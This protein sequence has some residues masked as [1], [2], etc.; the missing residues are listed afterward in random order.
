MLLK[1]KPSTARC[2]ESMYINYLLSDPDNATC[3][4][5]SEILESVSHDSINLFLHRERFTPKDLF[6][7]EKEKIE[8][9]GGI[10]SIDDTV[11]DKP[12][13]DL[14]KSELIGMYWSGKHK[15]T[16][17]GINL[18]TLFYTDIQGVSVPVNFR[19]YDKRE[20]KTKNDYFL[21]ML[22]ESLAWGINPAWVTGDSW[23][24]ST[25]NLKKI[26]R[27]NLNFL[28]GIEQN[29]CVSIERGQYIQVQKLEDWSQ[30]SVE[31]YL[32]NYGMVKVFRQVY[33][34]T[35]RYYIM[36]MADLN[37]LD[38]IKQIDFERVHD[39]HWHIERYH[40]ATKQVCNI[41]RFQVREENAVKNHV[42]CAL[43]AFV[44]LEIG[45][46]NKVIQNWYQVKRELFTKV[47]R[48]FIVLDPNNF[49]AV[50][51]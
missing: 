30:G 13:S 21:E 20:E 24:A 14:S 38:G 25:G 4:R 15:K 9:C 41:E 36:G 29:R 46:F 42:F 51:A 27:L 44:C 19:I 35:Y 17:K 1:C 12:Y 5:L 43:K 6:D 10:L 8:L 18:I 16:V 2:N 3:T 7:S 45:R 34:N 39:G 28:F 48:D 47:I 23:Y 40:R 49:Q 37:D 22:D 11:L 32:K 31:S 33:K 26:R 50:N